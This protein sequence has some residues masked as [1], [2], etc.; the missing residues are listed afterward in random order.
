MKTKFTLAAA[1]LTAAVSLSAQ[2]SATIKLYPEQAK[3]II[4]KEI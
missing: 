4:P 1:L 2:K 3:E